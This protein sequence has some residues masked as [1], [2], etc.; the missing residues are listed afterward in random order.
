MGF[1]GQQL[2]E[3]GLRRFRHF[4]FSKSTL[5][6][7]TRFSASS[8]AVR[9]RSESFCWQTSR[10]N[11]H[12]A[13]TAPITIS[14]EAVSAGVFPSSLQQSRIGAQFIASDLIMPRSYFPCQELLFIGSN[15]LEKCWRPGYPG[16]DV[17]RLSN[18]FFTFLAFRY[19]SSQCNNSLTRPKSS[20]CNSSGCQRRYTLQRGYCQNT[21]RIG[22]TPRVCRTS[23]FISSRSSE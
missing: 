1:P 4:L 18:W 8:T 6:C 23:I 14:S 20:W 11:S 5:L 16:T 21:L 2:I 10:E 17:N 15:G 7:V 12:N 3:W 22:W 19:L 9:D 13:C